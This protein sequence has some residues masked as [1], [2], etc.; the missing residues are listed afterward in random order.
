V[1]TV[2]V[3]RDLKPVAAVAICVLAPVT[4]ELLF[5]GI[6]VHQLALA[7]GSIAPALAV[8]LVVNVACHFY[9]GP[10]QIPTHA[11]LFALNAVLLFSP[12][13]LI[14]AIGAHVALNVLVSATL[15]RQQR[16]YHARRRQ[17]AIARLGSRAA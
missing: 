2:L 5:R 13:G 8:G 9:Q 14:G 17:R 16:R 1:A 6:L 3:R 10:W 11:A 12:L 4:E 15:R 7:S